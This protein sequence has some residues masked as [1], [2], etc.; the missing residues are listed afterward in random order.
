V[1]EGTGLGLAIVFKIIQKHFGKINV[2]SEPG[3]GATF[4]ITL[5]V[6]LNKILPS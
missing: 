1:G 3:M 6:S 5:P 4:I 2:E